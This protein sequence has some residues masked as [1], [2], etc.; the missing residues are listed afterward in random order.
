MDDLFR[1]EGDW[2]RLPA[3]AVLAHRI[4][5]LV[6]NVAT[7]AVITGAAWLFTNP[8]SWPTL[9][10][11]AA[12]IGWTIWR[13]VRA[14]RWVRSFRYSEREHDLLISHGLWVR[15]LTA[16][17][18]GRMLSVEVTTGPISRLWGL[19]GVHLV[20]ASSDSNAEIPSLPSA[21]AAV[22]RDRLITAGETQA[23]P[24]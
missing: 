5:A 24:L 19:A 8:E 16:V 6:T 9:V 1:P 18:Y 17:P 23:L 11:G 7:W 15:K 20:T 2:S 22:L 12:G 10:A 4:S 3:V 13:V 14:G 21:D